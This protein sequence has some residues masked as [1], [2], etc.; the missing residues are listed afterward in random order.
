MNWHQSSLFTTAIVLLGT[1]GCKADDAP[2]DS[3]PSAPPTGYAWKTAYYKRGFMGNYK[4]EWGDGVGSTLRI[5][6]PMPFAGSAVRVRLQPGRDI[7][8][9]LSKMGYNSTPNM[10]V[11]YPDLLGQLLGSPP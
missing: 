1:T 7:P 2:A 3:P 6:V 11:R 10:P 5:R 8:V 4:T 9:G